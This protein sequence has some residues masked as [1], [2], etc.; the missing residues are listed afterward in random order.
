MSA[1][2]DVMIR[3]GINAYRAGKKD[4]ARTL[5]LKAVELDEQNEQAWMWLSAVVDTVED[6]K[7]CLENALTINPN[8]EKARQGLRMLSE[9][10]A[11]SAAVTAPSSPQSPAPASDD[12]AFANLSFTQGPPPATTGPFSTPSVAEE[13]ELPTSVAWDVP[14]TETSSASTTYRPSNEPS[15]SDYDNWVAGLNLGTSPAPQPQSADLGAN[16]NASPF[17]MDDDISFGFDEED[18]ALPDSVQS[19]LSPAARLTPGMTSTRKS[20]SILSRPSL[21]PF[22]NPRRSRRHSP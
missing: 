3:E 14:A 12:D 17:V 11:G 7:T 22:P 4:E 20:P 16:F 1:N 15:A 19:S 10:A 5:L 8:N 2:V 18:V 9:K 6:Q 21:R 13:D